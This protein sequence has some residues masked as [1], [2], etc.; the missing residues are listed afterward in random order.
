MLEF[1]LAY[2][3]VVVYF[4][5]IVLLIVLIVLGIKLINTITKIDLIVDNI[6]RKFESLNPIFNAFDFVTDR[7][8]G[9]SDTVVDMFSGFLGKIIGNKKRGD[10]DGE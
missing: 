6:S 3:P 2:L 5:L 7:I 10:K 8:S 9:L 4:L 1:W